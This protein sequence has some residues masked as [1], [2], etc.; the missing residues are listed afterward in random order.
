M[1]TEEETH[2]RVI[3]AIQDILNIDLTCYIEDISRIGMK[4][5]RRPIRIEL[6]SKRIAK[7]ILT[8]ACYFKNLAVSELLD[9]QSLR[10]RHLLRAALLSARRKGKHAVIHNN[11]LQINGKEVNIQD[12]QTSNTPKNEKTQ[13][14]LFHVQKHTSTQLTDQPHLPNLPNQI[15]DHDDASKR[16]NQRILNEQQH[17]LEHHPYQRTF[18]DF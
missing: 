18:R 10:E 11:K 4:G 6:M 17:Q 8:N 16:G 13:P 9:E 3:Y 14:Q 2:D 12:L 15:S 5:F 1:G 7:Y